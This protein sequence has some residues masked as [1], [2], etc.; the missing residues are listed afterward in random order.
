MGYANVREYVGGKKDW[1][2]AGLQAEGRRH[3]RL[4]ERNR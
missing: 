4:R 2:D 3:E 1:V